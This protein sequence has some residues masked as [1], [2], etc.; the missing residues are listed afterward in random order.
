MAPAL[1]ERVARA[2]YL[3]WMAFST[4]TLEPAVLEQMRIRKAAEY[5][6]EPI[7]LGPALTPFDNVVSYVEATLAAH[8]FLMGEAFGAADIMN[9]SVFMWAND[10]GLLSGTENNN[11]ENIHAWLL[12]LKARPAFKRAIA[13]QTKGAL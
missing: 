12:R 3:K 11:C 4:G 7:D 6:L 8:P 5:G 10:M 9:G 1:G 2:E 13:Q